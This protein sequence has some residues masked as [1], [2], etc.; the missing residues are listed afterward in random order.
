MSDNKLYSVNLHYADPEL[1][2]SDAC[3]TGEDFAT[4]KEARQCIADFLAGKPTC[5]DRPKLPGYYAGVPY[6][7]L[8]G[9]NVNEIVRRSAQIKRQQREDESYQRMERS[10]SAMQAG[11]MG[12]IQA[13]NEAMGCDDSEPYEP[14]EDPHVWSRAEYERDQRKNAH[15]VG[16]FPRKEKQ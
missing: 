13:Y 15:F 16:V 1:P 6:I 11:M 5:F 10:E 4:E 3:A 14:E 9:P 8:D 2:D 12:G 7:E